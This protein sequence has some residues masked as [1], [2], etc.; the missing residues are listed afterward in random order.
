MKMLRWDGVAERLSRAARIQ[1]LYVLLNAG[2]KRRAIAKLCGVCPGAVSNWLFSS[3]HHPSNIATTSLLKAAWSED[4]NA[5]R[6]ILR[7]EAGRFASELRKLG[8]KLHRG[9]KLSTRSR[10]LHRG[11]KFTGV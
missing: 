9:V 2:L 8:I 1:L 11:V 4:P 7:D 5:V 10:G 6:N 3:L